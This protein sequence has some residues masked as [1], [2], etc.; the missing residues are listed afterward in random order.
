MC[1]C[2][3]KGQRNTQPFLD[4]KGTDSYEVIFDKF[5][6]LHCQG[7]RSAVLQYHSGKE[8]G[9]G[10]LSRFDETYFETLERM[11]R[12]CRE[13]NMTYWVQD[14]APFPTGAAD[15]RF[16]EPEWADRGKRYLEERH[17]LVAGPV[18]SGMLLAGA[19]SRTFQGNGF[20]RAVTQKQLSLPPKIIGVAALRLR[21]QREGEKPCF[22]G[23]S[24]I[25][26]TAGLQP[27]GTL[28]FDLPEGIWRIFLLCESRNGGRPGY[29]NLLDADSVAVQIEAVYQVHYERLKEELGKTWEGFFYDEPEIG[30]APYYEFDNL[31]GKTQGAL[32]WCEQMPKLLADRLGDGWLLRLPELWYDCG[33]QTHVT[34]FHFMDV[35]TR[36]VADNYNGQVHKWC[37]ERSI[38]YIG[39]VLEDENSH[40]RLGCGPGHFFRTQRRQD[41]AGIDLIGGQLSPG[42]DVR[43]ISWY[44]DQDGDGRFYHYGIAKLASSEGHLNLDKKG[45][46][47][48]EVNAVYGAISDPKRY[49]YL[50]DHLF[51][52]GVNNLV[53]VMDDAI[54]PEEGRL[55][56]SY[57]DRMCALL[58]G[59]RPK[60]AVAILYHAESEWA[61]DA[62]LFHVPAKELATHQIDYF[63]LPGDALTDKAFYHTR[64][65]QGTLHVGDLSLR[66]ILVP[67]C[68]YIRKDVLLALQEAAEGGLQVS[69]VDAL[70]I[71]YCEN[72]EPICWRKWT[73]E[74]VPLEKVAEA[75]K[76]WATV[77]CDEAVHNLR[78]ASWEKDGIWYWFFLNAGTGEVETTVRLP[79]AGETV[80]CDEMT[81]ERLPAACTVQTGQTL[82]PLAL[83]RYES[84]L[85]AVN[86]ASP[87]TAAET[88][89]WSEICCA[90]W[91]LT[92]EGDETVHHLTHL[93]DLGSDEVFRRCSRMLRYETTWYVSD[94]LPERLDLGTVCD[95]AR[96]WL[97]GKELGLRIAEPYCFCVAGVVHKGENWLVVE[98]RPSPA[99]DT[100]ALK[101]GGIFAGFTATVY[102]AMEPVGLLGPVKRA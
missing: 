17:T 68:T 13:L 58:R 37:R 72:C 8:T 75:A 15:G 36:L 102:A 29:M 79:V 66:M 69:F 10:Q 54:Q 74:L 51:L 81:Q 30:N 86:P 98:V 57:A 27:D 82:L 88:P 11:S 9:F 61:G 28:L 6:K 21:P 96:V 48:C 56:F 53:P 100:D 65:E 62:Q 99:R 78:S 91:T 95:S 76:N 83:G 44:S 41:M 43:G 45:D 24:A 63:V 7:V 23:N 47:F 49:K 32:P 60:A 89:V 55:L 84:W 33:E 12:V 90:P 2:K 50:L 64:L 46:S 71:G 87:T 26:L 40:G 39:H 70:Q 18:R 93:H 67:R 101:Q 31:P 1:Q 3:Y 42:L 38:R 80:V 16:F 14:A 35:V 20:I 34:R 77:G 92:V 5:R 22:D 97:N 94:R 25:D 59:S 85:I 4:V 73:P 19:L 52:N